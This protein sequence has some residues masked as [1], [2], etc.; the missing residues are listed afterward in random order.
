MKKTRTKKSFVASLVSM[1]LCVAML[2]GATYA[3]FTDSVTSGV[4]KITAGNLDVD[5]EY[6]TDLNTWAPVQGADSIFAKDALWE[7]GRTEVVYL[8]I[9]NLGSLALKYQL[10]VTAASEKSGINVN[11]EAYKLSDY[12][13]FGQVEDVTAVYA[14]RAAAVAAVDADAGLISAGYAAAGN[15]AKGADDKVVA[16]VVYMPESVGNEA[17]YKTGTTPASINLGVNLVATQD[18]VEN[19]SFG[20]NYDAGAVYPASNA[21]EFKEAIAQAEAGD[22]VELTG[23][24]TLA[25]KNITI[26]DG[27]EIKGNGN[28]IITDGALYTGNNAKIT[29]VVFDKVDPDETKGNAS[30][31]YAT[32]VEGTTVIDGCTFKDAQWDAL[33]I[34]PKAGA[35]IVITNNVFD[36]SDD[37]TYKVGGQGTAIQG[38][39]RY[40]HVEVTD[41]AS[42]NSNDIFLTV[43]GNKF[44]NMTADN[45]SRNDAISIDSI[46]LANITVGKNV[47]D[48]TDF[49]RELWLATD[50]ATNLSTPEIV[51]QFLAATTSKLA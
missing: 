7:P 50:R 29:D 5:V 1:L 26:A 42:R 51:A 46:P 6:S 25:D 38:T 14:D 11:D 32:G 34:T 23:T 37:N 12:I 22:K 31:V 40:I 8:K 43:T 9:A 45:F 13:K 36:T 15:M 30:F 20:T 33:Q 27:V 39:Y 28:T 3:W 44:I 19:D 10:A 4:N 48:T 41:V 2:I 16:L 24:V 18:T 47:A 21:A 17:N 35:N 49:A